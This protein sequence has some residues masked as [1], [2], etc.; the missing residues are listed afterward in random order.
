[1]LT[2][3]YLKNRLNRHG[4]N[5]ARFGVG[6]QALLHRRSQSYTHAKIGFLVFDMLESIFVISIFELASNK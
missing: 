2:Q 1:M 4:Y 3:K 5:S 6:F